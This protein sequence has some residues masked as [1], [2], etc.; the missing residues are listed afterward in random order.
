MFDSG[1]RFFTQTR[2]QQ[3]DQDEAYK[4]NEVGGPN[5][6]MKTEGNVLRVFWGICWIGKV[7]VREKLKR[8]LNEE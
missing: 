4:W 1:T 6:R 7:L 2:R 8:E 5:P 3:T